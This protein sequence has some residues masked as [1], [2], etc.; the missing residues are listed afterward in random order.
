MRGGGGEPNT[1]VGIEKRSEI[2]VSER[3]CR[4]TETVQTA[5]PVILAA[6]V[7]CRTTAT[8]RMIGPAMSKGFEI[9]R[10]H[11]L[12]I[13]RT[14]HVTGLSNRSEVVSCRDHRM[15]AI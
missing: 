15:W 4:V 3:R 7:K 14:C 9:L 6:T 10:A 1:L 5:P 12:L 13:E 2:S 8:I 11:G